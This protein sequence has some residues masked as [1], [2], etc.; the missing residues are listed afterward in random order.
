MNVR[1]EVDAKK[2]CNCLIRILKL[3]HYSY[4][5]HFRNV[6]SS[7]FAFDTGLMGRTH[8]QTG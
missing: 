6:K 4:H 7:S 1:Y 3:L 8:A 5:E 2:N